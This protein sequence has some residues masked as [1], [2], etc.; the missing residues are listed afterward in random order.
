MRKNDA[1]LACF[2]SCVRGYIAEVRSADLDTLEANFEM[3]SQNGRAVA[4]SITRH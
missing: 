1:L 3:L 4:V 2:G